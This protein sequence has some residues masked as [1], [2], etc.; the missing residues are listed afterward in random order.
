MEENRGFTLITTSSLNDNTDNSSPAEEDTLTAEQKRQLAGV[1]DIA[2]DAPLLPESELIDSSGTDT[3]QRDISKS[4]FPRTLL[5]GGGILFLLAVAL[6]SN[7]L[8]G[9]GGTKPSALVAEEAE[10]EE[11][12]AFDPTDTYKTRLALL[13]Q[14]REQQPKLTVP[15]EATQPDQ[16]ADSETSSPEP[17]TV[18]TAVRSTPPAPRPVPTPHPVSRPR[19]DSPATTEPV[20]PLP[21]P[22]LDPNQQWQT[23]AQLGATGHEA[24]L[25]DSV[26][27]TESS[28]AQDRASSRSENSILSNPNLTP[29][30]TP[31]STL[32]NGIL[33]ASVGQSIASEAS[34]TQQLSTGAQGILQ[35][36]P[37]SLIE[38]EASINATESY[39]VA[40]GSTA[41]AEVVTPIVAS[42]DGKT[43]GRFAVRLTE[44]L[45]DIQGREALPAGSVLVTEVI[46][47]EDESRVI[48]QNAVALVYKNRAGEIQQETIASNALVVR[49]DQGGPLIANLA[50][51]TSMVDSSLFLIGGAGALAE[52]GDVLNRS[53]IFTATSTSNGS[54]S[55]STT[56][57]IS[58]DDPN[59]LG[60]ALAGFFRAALDS[61]SDRAEERAESHGVDPVLFVQEGQSV[62]IFVNS[63][64][65]IHR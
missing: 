23:L 42:K 13:D 54:T 60:A 64:L 57:T 25:L 27:E 44:P 45:L 15:S 52:I 31:A 47:I 33:H 14:Q 58:N 41:T 24:T 53:D 6:I 4:P 32:N 59:I 19:P 35:R 56:T 34:N 30:L 5:V 55:T 29:T 21:E 39:Q 49:G 2:E 8:G 17:K 28:L 10:P 61:A 40:I 12:T 18:T 37:T 1:E 38:A 7:I 3:P 43:V 36:R 26:L 16:P 65:T 22:T 46:E 9:G 11:T 51:G 63:F 62:E 20:K 48:H 50:G